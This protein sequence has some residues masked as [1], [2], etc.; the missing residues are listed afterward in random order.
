MTIIP[1]SGRAVIWR[2]INDVAVETR[3]TPEPGEK[4]VL[5]RVLVSGLCATDL[6][7]ARGEY[8]AAKPRVVLG[9]E[10]A[11]EVVAVGDGVKGLSVGDL[12]AV[13][14][15]IPCLQCAS[16]G[17]CCAV[18]RNGRLDGS[19]LTGDGGADPTL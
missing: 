14:P 5:V 19:S 16:G 18:W 6:H 15:N 2:D 9:H 1:T 3:P 17:R 11:G 12:V 8:P 4:E 13:D 10:Y 7:I